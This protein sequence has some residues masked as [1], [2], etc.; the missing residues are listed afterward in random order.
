MNDVE[1]LS[2]ADREFA[3]LPENTRNEILA[4]VKALAAE[5]TVA[6]SNLGFAVAR[7]AGQVAVCQTDGLLEGI[8]VL[9]LVDEKLWDE[10][11]KCA[12]E[13]TD[14]IVEQIVWPAVPAAVRD[15]RLS[16]AEIYSLE[17][18]ITREMVDMG[19]AE[20][21]ALAIGFGNWVAIC[22]LDSRG[23]V[24]ILTLLP[25]FGSGFVLFSK[26]LVE[27]ADGREVTYSPTPR[28]SDPSVP[29]SL[30]APSGS[31]RRRGY[32]GARS[33]VWSWPCSRTAKTSRAWR[34]ESIPCPR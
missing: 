32:R 19:M 12:S 26:H 7:A 2:P 29:T 18:S 5:G 23:T 14:V 33:I 30:P 1:F 15:A 28:P 10:G 34:C 11:A 27:K 6:V 3:A 16:A 25:L 8:Q 24:S 21:V 22:D 31:R 17:E 4:A 20:V 9:L 13:S